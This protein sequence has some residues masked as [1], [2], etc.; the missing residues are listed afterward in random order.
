[1]IVAKMRGSTRVN[2][3]LKERLHVANQLHASSSVNGSSISSGGSG[4][5]R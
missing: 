5:F 3:N 1:M 4:G 2:R